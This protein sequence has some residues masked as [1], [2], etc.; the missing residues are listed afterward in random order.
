VPIPDVAGLRFGDP[1]L[2]GVLISHP[3]L[4][5]YGLVAD[6]AVDV[7]LFIGEAAAILDA[8]AFFSPWRSLSGRPGSCDREVFHL[9]PFTI[10]AT[11]ADLGILDVGGGRP[12]GPQGPDPAVTAWAPGEIDAAAEPDD[13]DLELRTRLMLRHFQRDLSANCFGDH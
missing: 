9:G 13:S 12:R 7:P 11:P 3:R 6:L 4:D 2:L 10:V 8:A 1:A 5:H